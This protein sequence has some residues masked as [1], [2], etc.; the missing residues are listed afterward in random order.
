MLATLL[1]AALDELNFAAAQ[2]GIV[3]LELIVLRAHGF[4]NANLFVRHAAEF[5]AVGLG[6]LSNQLGKINKTGWGLLLFVK[7]SHFQHEIIH[8]LLGVQNASVEGIAMPNLSAPILEYL[9]RMMITVLFL[10]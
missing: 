1:I 5:V 6:P 4:Q 9:F 3:F 7:L 2:G 8:V 10:G